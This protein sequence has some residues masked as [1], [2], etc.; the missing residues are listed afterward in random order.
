MNR[1]QVLLVEDDVVVRTML[2]EQLRASGCVVCSVES[3]EAAVAQLRARRFDLVVTDLVLEQM[4]GLGVVR[5]ARR[6][7][8]HLEIVVITGVATLE[9]AIAACNHGPCRYLLKP[10]RPGEIAQIAAEAAA[11][12]RDREAQADLLRRMLA[13]L[14]QFPALQAPNE[15]A[16][17]L[18]ERP[19][20]AMLRVG[21]LTIDARRHLV[22]VAEQPVQL[23]SAQF[24]LLL[25]MARRSEQV[26]SPQQLARD[27]LDYDFSTAAARDLLKSHI[28][29]LRHKIEADP[30]T[31]RRLLCVRGVGYKL[32]AGARRD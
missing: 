4:D 27:V 3:G 16:G 30:A 14:G 25:Y 31:P 20:E 28:H 2:A 17:P 21:E 11:R 10:V 7:D 19:D 5:A 22:T 24:N 32:T 26:I 1:A 6:S 13:Q 18:P 29:K 8:P 12:R 15:P 9:S 23:S